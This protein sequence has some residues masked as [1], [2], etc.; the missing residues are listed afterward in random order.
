MAE[1]TQE[2]PRNPADHLKAWRWRPGQ[3][4]PNPA[5][6]P[7]A[8]WFREALAA[9]YE[10]NPERF[11]R[12]MERLDEDAQSSKKTLAKHARDFLRDTLDGPLEHRLAANDGGPLVI[13]QPLTLQGVD[14]ERM[15]NPSG[16]NGNG[17]T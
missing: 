17:H 9:F 4:S 6:R 2:Q 1:I 13:F 12:L 8:K 10:A 14:P 15:R 11:Q 16:S 3:P 5:G 7:A